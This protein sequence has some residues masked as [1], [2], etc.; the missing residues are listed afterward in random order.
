M[1]RKI[2]ELFERA[3]ECYAQ[4]HTSLDADEK[5]KLQLIGDQLLQEAH[6]LA[7]RNADWMPI[8]KRKR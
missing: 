3:R 7:D 1:A 2:Q 4:A 8:V 5:R 6:D